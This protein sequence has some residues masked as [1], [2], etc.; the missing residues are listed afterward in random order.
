MDRGFWTCL[1][2]CRHV[3]V[4]DALKEL[5][6]GTVPHALQHLACCYAGY[7]CGVAAASMWGPVNLAA[8]SPVPPPSQQ[9]QL[10]PT[11][12][13]LRIPTNV[14]PCFADTNLLPTADTACARRILNYLHALLAP[15]W[16]TIRM[17]DRNSR[18]PPSR[19]KLR[20][21]SRRRLLCQHMVTMNVTWRWRRACRI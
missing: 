8:L 18:A 5:L 7:T 12:S 19:S 3:G 20:P 21:G 15:A 17:S 13:L 11:I 16:L 4:F 2:K 6:L 1:H 9:A 14:Q 10:F